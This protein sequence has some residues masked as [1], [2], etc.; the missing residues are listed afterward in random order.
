MYNKI[1][2]WF[3]F[4]PQ[5]FKYHFAWLSSM[6]AAALQ[7]YEPRWIIFYND[8]DF[9]L[10]RARFVDSHWAFIWTSLYM[11]IA[12]IEALLYI[13]RISIIKQRVY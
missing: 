6:T 5:S 8:N 13:F 1:V 7:I 2:I 3:A 10:R 9:F 12:I 11:P 4:K